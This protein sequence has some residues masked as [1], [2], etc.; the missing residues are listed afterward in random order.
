M[1]SIQLWLYEESGL[2]KLLY[3]FEQMLKHPKEITNYI[4]RIGTNFSN[5]QTS[6]IPV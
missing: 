3:S 2:Q 1:L 4:F 6:H 5:F